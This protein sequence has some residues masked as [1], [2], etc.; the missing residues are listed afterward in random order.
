V[1]TITCSLAPCCALNSVC[2][3]YTTCILMLPAHVFVC[4]FHVDTTRP[5]C[6]SHLVFFGENILIIHTEVDKLRSSSLPKFSALLWL[7]F[8][9]V[10]VR[11]ISARDTR[12][13][14]SAGEHSGRQGCDAVSLDVWFPTSRRIQLSR[15]TLE[16][17]G[18]TTLRNVG[19]PT[20][21]DTV[22]HPEKTW[23]II[24]SDFPF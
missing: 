21:N 19:N 20:L 15:V 13:S 7:P 5:T 4:L 18:T 10:S 23:T 1:F 12:S 2:I 6:F 8:S 17:D 16:D 14:S 3:V 9:H 24:I 11:I 22:S